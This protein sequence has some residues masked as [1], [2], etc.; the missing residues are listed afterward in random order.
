LMAA[1]LIAMGLGYQN[2][3]RA[4]IAL[5]WGV[6]AAGILQLALL[7][8]GARRSGMGLR[9]VRP[10]FSPDVKRLVQLGVPGVIAG[11]ITQLNILIG[12]VIA[13]L[14]DGAVSQLY[15]ADRIYELPL[16]LVGI[17]VGV[18]LLPD[19]ARRLRAG[20]DVGALDS[21]NRSLELAMLLTVPAAVAL[22]IVPMPI[23]QVLFERGAFTATDSLATA[24]A[25]ALFAF[26]L[27]GFVLIKVFSPGFFAR[28]DTRTPMIM[29][30]ISLTLNT[31]G[32]LAFFFVFRE[33][34][35]MP[36]LGIALATTLGGWLNALLLFG[37]LTRRGYFQSDRR[38]RRALPLIGVASAVMAGVLWWLADLLA[39]AFVAGQGLAI[40]AAA[41]AGLVFAG[42]ATYA[43][44][45]F[46][47]G[48]VKPGDVRRAVRR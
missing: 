38:L 14:Q 32:S 46:V 26:G 6:F 4:G 7:V 5:A 16:A 11:G 15:Y 10:R 47:L 2:D 34:G 25:L 33:A 44:A 22:A 19:V 18:V 40:R 42:G 41:L 8:W 36:H 12:T 39:P 37:A 27:P 35:L 45:A 48:L 24:S 1:I 23:V 9:I 30:G 3:P 13:S 28:E 43:V 31:L 21:Q 29:A 20:D 17:A